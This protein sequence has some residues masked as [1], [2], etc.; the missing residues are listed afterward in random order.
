[1]DELPP[2]ISERLIDRV[3]TYT[4]TDPLE[5]PPLYDTIDPE[6]LDDCIENLDGVGLSFHYAGVAVAVDSDGDI[7]LDDPATAT[8]RSDAETSTETTE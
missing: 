4:D 7:T 8:L 5:L 3:A 2:A 6:S 1:M